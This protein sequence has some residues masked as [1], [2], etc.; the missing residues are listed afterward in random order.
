MATQQL[1]PGDA[2]PNVSLLNI[3]GKPESLADYWSSG[4]TLLDFLRHFG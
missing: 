2:A 4:P 1:K 3:Q